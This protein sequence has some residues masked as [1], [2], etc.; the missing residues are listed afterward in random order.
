MNDRAKRLADIEAAHACGLL[1][2]VHDDRDW[3]LSEVRD[4]D[5]ALAAL[6]IP[7]DGRSLAERI[8]AICAARNQIEAMMMHDAHRSDAR[9]LD[10]CLLLAE[11][12]SILEGHPKS[13]AQRI[14][15]CEL[16]ALAEREK[17]P[18]SSRPGRLG[19]APC[20]SGA[21]L[22]VSA[23]Q[24]LSRDGHSVESVMRLYPYLTREQVDVA[25]AYEL[26]EE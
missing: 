1:V 5:A 11:V 2:G 7:D 12:V 25:L 9:S 19:G 14:K 10:K 20:I 17:A 21:R 6:G 4:A 18:I 13:L 8:D 3:L 15:E 23:L 22:T 24:A 16:R 26:P